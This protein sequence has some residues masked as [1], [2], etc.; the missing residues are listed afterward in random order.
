MD[1]LGQL[2]STIASDIG[3]SDLTSQIASAVAQAH[4]EVRHREFYFNQTRDFTFST[5]VDQ[6]QYTSSVTSS[7]KGQSI[8]LTDFWNIRNVWLDIT[9]RRRSL[10]FVPYEAM[11]NRLDGSQSKG[12]P[13][14]WSW[15]QEE[16]WLY[17]V[18]SSVFTVRVAGHYNLPLPSSDA[19][20]NA[21]ITDAGE[22]LRE[23]A[24][25]ILYSTRINSPDRLK[26]AMA[27]KA[28]TLSILKNKTF[29]KAQRLTISGSEM[30]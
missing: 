27:G 26:L 17:P 2:K 18:P 3:R 22:Y 5:V 11:E 1:N 15:Y 4:D 23:A 7:I 24:K 20:S 12:E 19:D 13:Y 10:N 30:C 25:E 9:N 29:R 6:Y 16:L 21:W 8:L 28:K 14:D